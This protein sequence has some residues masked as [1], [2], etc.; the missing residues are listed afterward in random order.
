MKDKSLKI[1]TIAFRLWLIAIL[2]FFVCI[3]LVTNGFRGVIQDTTFGNSQF[4]LILLFISFILGLISFPIGVLNLTY[5][6]VSKRKVKNKLVKVLLFI[7][8]LFI[9][10]A[11]IL[12][13]WLFRVVGLVK[14][15]KISLNLLKKENFLK[16]I[17]VLFVIL[18][19]LPIWLTGY[20]VFGILT[21]QLILSELGYSPVTETIVGTGSMYPTF[22]KG[23]KLTPKEQYQEIVAK[24]NFINYPSG[25]VIFGKRYFGRELKRGD[26]I[27]FQNKKTEEETKKSFGIATG[28]LKRLIALPGDTLMLKSGIVYLNGKPLREPYIAKPR[29]TFA[30]SYLSECVEIN[31]PPNKI[32]VMG[33]NR[34]GSG[35]S[36]E[37]GFVDF[38]EIDHVL[39]IENQ[40]GTW[41]KNYRDTSKDL[42]EI[43]KIKIDKEKY[44]ALLNSKRKEAGRKLLQYQP[45]LEK[46]AN[47]RGEI[48]LKFDDFS[49]K[50]TK[51]GYT[52]YKAMLDA[53]YSNITYGEAP[54]QGYFEA[55]ELIDNQFQF[56]KTKDFLLNKDYQEIGISEVE[57]KINNCPTQ[58]IIQHFAGYVPPNYTKD[59]IESWEK[60][61][62]GLKNIQ[63]GWQSLKQYPQVYGKN[64]SDVDIINDIISQR[65]S[66]IEGIVASMK[67]NQW[68]TPEQDKYTQ[69]TD[70]LL[71]NE[72]NSLAD[73]L[74][75][76]Y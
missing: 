39:P 21:S 9:L 62:S 73:K 42:A 30:E 37:I 61:L 23:N 75:S 34:K 71:A 18:F 27:T 40:K 1:Y 11:Y 51:S 69:T 59:V 22:P 67:A 12:I 70:E 26:I 64:K 47:L 19:L 43:S 74:N 72:Q 66:M 63:S 76:I 57:G 29:S 41:D 52:M 35:D 65:I 49:W 48:I 17:N 46:S 31:I 25:I 16:L 54:T 56:P 36:R 45:K 53:N 68:L 8:I 20:L 32:F 55:D 10:P 4:F 38:K 13:S 15:K 58:L 2:A 6:L 44:L 33:D 5:S 14:N 7:G 24:A 50:A 60:A 28:F 3:A